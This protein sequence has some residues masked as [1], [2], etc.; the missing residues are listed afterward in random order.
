MAGAETDHMPVY[1]RVFIR[2]L[3]S[4][5]HCP[6]V[7][8]QAHFS[9]SLN[10]GSEC[11]FRAVAPHWPRGGQS[12]D[13]GVTSNGWPRPRLGQL[14]PR[15]AWPGVPRSSGPSPSDR[16]AWVGGRCRV[17]ERHRLHRHPEA[18]TPSEANVRSNEYE[19][20]RPLPARK[21]QGV[22]PGL[23]ILSFKK[24]AERFFRAVQRERLRTR[25]A[26]RPSRRLRHARAVREEGECRSPP[27]RANA[28]GAEELFVFSRSDSRELAALRCL[29]LL[30]LCER[31]RR[32]SA[33]DYD[34]QHAKRSEAPW[35]IA[36]SST[37]RRR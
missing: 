28:P 21:L 8:G 35:L 19:Y 23:V 10:S 22:R 9:E 18:S 36:L 14:L 6:K 1:L 27:R 7:P 29:A 20:G 34:S 5:V 3:S 37:G 24:G 16:R 30:P 4:W 12:S 33:G 2:V 17:R 25:A 32:P 15:P 26:N 11:A 31:L 13:Q